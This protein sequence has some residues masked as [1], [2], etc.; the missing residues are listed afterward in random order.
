MNA[1]T[2]HTHTHTHTHAEFGN[3]ISPEEGFIIKLSN[4]EACLHN[5]WDLKLVIYTKQI[6]DV[7]IY[8]LRYI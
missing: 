2:L 3:E 1:W 4:N 5:S 7:H 6:T 8:I